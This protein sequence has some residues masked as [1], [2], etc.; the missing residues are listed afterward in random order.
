MRDSSPLTPGPFDAVNPDARILTP[1]PPPDP[2]RPWYLTLAF[3]RP[4]GI[5]RPN[6]P[7][8]AFD[9][10]I[11]LGGIWRPNNTWVAFDAR[12]NFSDFWLHLHWSMHNFS[13]LFWILVWIP[14]WILFWVPIWRPCVL[15]LPYNP[16]VA[17]DTPI[18]TGWH[19]TPQ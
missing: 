13:I 8:V 3:W 11:P 2:W 10:P 12:N 6:N 16:K 1:W 7:W 5:W 4:C 18:I 14:F 19:L 9:A 15:W 17:F